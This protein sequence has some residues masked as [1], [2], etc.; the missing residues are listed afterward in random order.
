VQFFL[1]DQDHA[2][3]PDDGLWNK[4]LPM[5]RHG[6]LPSDDQPAEYNLTYGEYFSAVKAFFSDNPE[7]MIT[8]R[9]VAADRLSVYLEKHGAFYHPSRVVV[10]K[11]NGQS[12][13][14]LN[15]AV[16]K[17]GKRHLKNEY[18]ILKMLEKKYA[19]P[20]LPSVFACRDIAV[21]DSRAVSMF[22]GEWFGS[23]HEFHFSEKY[24]DSTRAIRVWDPDD[25]GCF[26]STEK[27]CSVFEQATAILTACYDIQTFERVSAWHHAAG[28]F[29]VNLKEPS[30]PSV[31]LVTV[32]QYAP[33]FTQAEENAEAVLN[34]LLL[35]LLNLS[36]HMRLD[37]LDGVG[38]I[39]WID[40]FALEGTL[41]GFL[42]GLEI[43]L[44]ND[45]LPSEF[46]DYFKSFLSEIPAEDIQS[47]FAGVAG[48]L[49]PALPEI[50]VIQSHLKAHADSFYNTIKT[51]L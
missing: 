48:R 38:E 36:I 32:R 40:R 43:Q 7:D 45:R 16:S 20:F 27:A 42:N 50:P 34:G 39:C 35:F 37:R 14:V 13:Y 11:E 21:D 9:V 23:Y 8:Q 1:S 26:L 33:L 28:D 4:S 44:G 15:V 47:L 31:K 46:V 17:A 22:M 49:N 5:T 3:N 10:S 19:Y 25:D 2:I 29:V 51:Q 6:G 24:Q 41:T 12:E 30:M 18:S